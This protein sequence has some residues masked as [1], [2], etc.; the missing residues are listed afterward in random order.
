MNKVSIYSYGKERPL[1][2]IATNDETD[3]FLESYCYQTSNYTD[4]LLVSITSYKGTRNIFKVSN[5]KLVIISA[6][7]IV[8]L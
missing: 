5:I 2:I 4:Q 1:I 8:H 7:D 6:K 3:K